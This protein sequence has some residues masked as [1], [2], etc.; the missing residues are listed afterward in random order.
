[1]GDVESDPKVETSPGEGNT[2]LGQNVAIGVDD[3]ATIPKGQIDPV[4]EAK[5]R[6]LNR[7]ASTT[8]FHSLT[9]LLPH[10]SYGS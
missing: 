5:A 6:V 1:M 10:V 3:E 8:Y 7:A 9:A 4:Y 2:K